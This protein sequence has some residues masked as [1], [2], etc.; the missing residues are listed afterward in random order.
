MHSPGYFF[1]ALSASIAVSNFFISFVRPLYYGLRKEKYKFVSVI[2][3]MG[4][5]LLVPAVFLL[6]EEI[7]LR[8]VALAIV[9]IDT[10]GLPWLFLMLLGNL[11]VR[12]KKKTS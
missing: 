12:W 10:G 7:F 4:N 8:Y 5:I 11:I 3:L 2:P 6:P 9:L 1:L